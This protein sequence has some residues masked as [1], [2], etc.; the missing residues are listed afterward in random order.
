MASTIIFKVG[1][2]IIVAKVVSTRPPAS[3]IPLAIGAA[4]LT[5]TPKGAPIAT[6]S[7]EFMNLLPW[8]RLFIKASRVINT[9]AKKD[10]KGHALFIG[11][12]PIDGVIDDLHN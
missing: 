2:L 5:Q 7:A 3:W 6:P 4:Q 12:S 1:E 11:I 9:A 10:A 8:P